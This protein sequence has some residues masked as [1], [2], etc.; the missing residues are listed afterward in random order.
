MAFEYLWHGLHWRRRL[1]SPS[2]RITS[3]ACRGMVQPT[4]FL[5]RSARRITAGKGAAARAFGA[6]AVLSGRG[7]SG[8]NPRRGSPTGVLCYR[9][10]HFP[11]EYR[12][13]F[14]LLTDLWPDLLLLP[15]EAAGASYT[16][17]PRVFLQSVGDTVFGARP[18]LRWIPG[19][20]RPTSHSRP[21]TR[22]AVY[23]IRH[24]TGFKSRELT[25]LNQNRVR[26]DWHD[27]WARNL[28]DKSIA[29]DAFERLQALK[30]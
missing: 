1:A 19:Q 7:R 18:A 30:S 22:G 3:A 2:I 15:L 17:K 10:T 5:S 24:T 12:G 6:G 11:P 29:D 28:L 9:H 16:G 27:G 8:G 13:A 14:F 4:L 21:G 26:F 23:R 25:K 20:R